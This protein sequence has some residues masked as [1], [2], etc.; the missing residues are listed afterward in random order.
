MGLALTASAQALRAQA[1]GLAVMQG[2]F[3]GTGFA[4]A[5]N[6]GRADGQTAILA[7]V[8][9]GAR[10]GGLHLDLGA[11]AL[12]GSRAGYRGT[13]AT[14]GGRLAVRVAQLFDARV[15]ITPFAGFGSTRGTVERTNRTVQ[16]DQTPIGAAIGGR[17]ALGSAGRAV[18][19]SAAPFY[20]L[21]RQSGDSLETKTTGRVRATLSA[22][23]AATPHVGVSLSVEAGQNAGATGIGPSGTL[24]SA[25][26]SFAFGRR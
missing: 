18:A 8:G 17:L 7:A 26:V 20:G 15:A 5:V 24:V 10:S 14:Y 2:A 4:A 21:Y 1:P 23:V 25:G 22:E 6:G 12:G 16:T 11:G 9:F 3:P 13:R 19:L